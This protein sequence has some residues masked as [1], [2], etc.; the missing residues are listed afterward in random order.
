MAFADS[1]LVSSKLLSL[2]LRVDVPDSSGDWA[3]LLLQPLQAGGATRPCF[4]RA[5]GLGSATAAARPAL[6]LSWGGA[7]ELSG[8]PG[9]QQA[10]HGRGGR[11]DLRGRRLKDTCGGQWGPARLPVPAAPSPLFINEYSSTERES[12]LQKCLDTQIL[13]DFSAFKTWKEVCFS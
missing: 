8:L 5:W 9:R 12:W 1:K 4:Q 13:S 10:H 6:T 3:R 2:S 11:L 7:G